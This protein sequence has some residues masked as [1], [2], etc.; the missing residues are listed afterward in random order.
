MLAV[1]SY[2]KKIQLVFYTA[3]LISGTLDESF[4]LL[5]QQE[6]RAKG[7]CVQLDSCCGPV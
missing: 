4:M 1:Q 2:R 6:S 7:V 3:L 5:T